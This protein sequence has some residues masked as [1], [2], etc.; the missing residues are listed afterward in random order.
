M[1]LM[2]IFVPF[3]LGPCFMILPAVHQPY[4]HDDFQLCLTPVFLCTILIRMKNMGP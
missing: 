4:F 3:V 1:V 2:V